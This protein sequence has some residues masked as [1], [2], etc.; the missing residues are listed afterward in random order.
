PLDPRS[1]PTRRS[2]DLSMADMS[3]QRMSEKPSN[4]S[5][6]MPDQTPFD[7]GLLRRARRHAA[8]FGRVTAFDVVSEEWV[9]TCIELPSAIGARSEEHTS[10]L[11][12]RENL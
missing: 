7:A 6:K 10:E 12:S 1:F 2:S 11:Q 9:S 5:K 4:S 8:Q 3:E